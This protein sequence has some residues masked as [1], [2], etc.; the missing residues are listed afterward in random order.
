[1][2]TRE[3][4]LYASPNGDRW[5]LV[6][7]GGTGQVF[8]RHGPSAPSG[9]R[10]RDIALAAFLAQGGSG[11]ETRELLRLIGSLVDEG[12]EDGTDSVA[13]YP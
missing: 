1:M 7:E 4:T 11:P 10:A 12:R 8:V 2:E 5:S 9:G 3:R 13:L 6:R